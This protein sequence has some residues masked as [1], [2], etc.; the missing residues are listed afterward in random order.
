MIEWEID[1][2]RGGDKYVYSL[3]ILC[4]RVI[5]AVFFYEYKFQLGKGLDLIN[6]NV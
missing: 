1:T 3:K 5:V 4:V 6:K 2:F